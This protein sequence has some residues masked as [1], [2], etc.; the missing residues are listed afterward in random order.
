MWTN[1][2][3]LLSGMHAYTERRCTVYVYALTKTHYNYNL[4]PSEQ[5]CTTS[6]HCVLIFV[7]I[8]EDSLHHKAFAITDCEKKKGPSLQMVK[9]L[10]K[11][12]PCIIGNHSCTLTPLLLVIAFT[13]GANYP[14]E[15]IIDFLL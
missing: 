3:H 12:Q 1:I 2:T 5:L 14:E 13:V 4:V 10:I 6:L 7:D 8:S 11:I 15:L 9:Q